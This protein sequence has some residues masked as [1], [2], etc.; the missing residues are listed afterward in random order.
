M[1][2]KTEFGSD[3]DLGFNIIDYPYLKDKSWHNDLSPSF[4]FNVGSQYYVLWVDYSDPLKREDTNYR[5]SIQKAIDE[6]D[7]M[8]PEVYCS[9]GDI[10]FESDNYLELS[11][12]LNSLISTLKS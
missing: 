3:F 5:Y 2:Y 1:K 8:N 7:E 4:Y 11:V 9:T 12:F 10:I 6:G